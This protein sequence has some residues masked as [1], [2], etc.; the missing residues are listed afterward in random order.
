MAVKIGR[1]R[2]GHRDSRFSEPKH[3]DSG[4]EF[5][6]GTGLSIEVDF[7]IGFV[8]IKLVLVTKPKLKSRRNGWGINM[9]PFSFPFYQKTTF[10]S[11]NILNWK[12]NRGVFQIDSC[13][14]TRN[15]KV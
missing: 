12:P 7:Y 9:D 3:R 15:E 11:E 5:R 8:S 2:E 4:F 13:F 10:L 6:L 1:A 14:R